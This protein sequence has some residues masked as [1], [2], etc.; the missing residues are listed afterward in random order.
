MVDLG[1]LSPA[2]RE[3]LLV[4]LR[5]R[6]YYVGRHAARLGTMNA[7]ERRGLVEP[8]SW[9]RLEWRLTAAGSVAATR[10]AKLEKR[11]AG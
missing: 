10:L 11:R 9:V 7:L 3:T 4:M 1:T 2:M 5:H 6:T 8:L